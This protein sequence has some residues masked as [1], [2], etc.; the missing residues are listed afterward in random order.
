MLLGHRFLALVNLCQRA[1]W[2]YIIN[3]DM[4]EII[5]TYSLSLSKNVWNKNVG[6]FVKILI[7]FEYSITLGKLSKTSRKGL[8]VAIRLSQLISV[9]S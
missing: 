3:S 2:N 1:D 7:H 4:S 5:F 9:E 8:P 6:L